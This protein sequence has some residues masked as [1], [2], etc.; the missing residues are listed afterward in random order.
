MALSDPRVLKGETERKPL[1]EN[2]DEDTTASSFTCGLEK[3]M[4][5]AGHFWG[6]SLIHVRKCHPL[7]PDNR[8]MRRV[9][10]WS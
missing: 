1:H 6:T 7:G 3:C 4:G 2:E 10:G 8:A 9:L 5:C